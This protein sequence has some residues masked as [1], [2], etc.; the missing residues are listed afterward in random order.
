MCTCDPASLS[1]QVHRVNGDLAV[2]RGFG[3]AEYVDGKS[4]R[5][6]ER[7][8]EKEEPLTLRSPP[9][10]LCAVCDVYHR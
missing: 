1:Y 9:C 2:S 8:R 7:K 6:K 5:E 4:E 10:V 3:D